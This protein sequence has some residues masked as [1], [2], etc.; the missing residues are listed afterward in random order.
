MILN[1]I[2][3][4]VHI[5]LPT[6]RPLYRFLKS[7]SPDY[8][9]LERTGISEHIFSNAKLFVQTDVNDTDINI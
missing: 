8:K 3:R 4:I 5:L 7:I 6:R 9:N 1:L 2:R